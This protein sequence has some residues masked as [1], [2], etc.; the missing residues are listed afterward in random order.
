[1]C[2]SFEEGDLI[3]HF[4]EVISSEEDRR[5]VALLLSQSTKADHLGFK[6]QA[7]DCAVESI[8]RNDE[9]ALALRILQLPKGMEDFVGE[10]L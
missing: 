7:D 6:A 10:V 3:D 1:M 2:E 4:L 9:R 8:F 5:V